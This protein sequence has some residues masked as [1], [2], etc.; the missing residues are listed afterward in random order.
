MIVHDDTLAKTKANLNTPEGIVEVLSPVYR[1][2]DEIKTQR[3]IKT[4]FPVDYLPENLKSAGSKIVYVAR[5]PRDVM[6]SWFHL[7]TSYTAIGFNKDMGT[8]V[9]YFV[10]G[11]DVYGPYWE[12][13]KSAWSHRH[14]KN[15]YFVFY[16]DF[17]YDLKGSLEK[18]A[19]FLGKTIKEED[20]PKFL[21]HLG[22]ESFRNNLAISNQYYTQAGLKTKGKTSFIRE[23]KIGGCNELTTEMIEKLDKW[24][25]EN[26]KGTD[27]KFPMIQK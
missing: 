26:L 3:V 10:K 7:S 5:N 4:H 11:M 12:H 16:E 1:I 9:D 23:G 22:I 8:F 25:E 2:L 20:Y 13:L 18:L 21:T 27:L 19:T 14:E 6:V 24:T 15:F 17:I